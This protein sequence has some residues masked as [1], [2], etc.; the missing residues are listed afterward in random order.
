MG[1]LSPET[2]LQLAEACLRRVKG[3]SKQRALAAEIARLRGAEALAELAAAADSE[4]RQR[5]DF[6]ADCE[7]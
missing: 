6:R 1:S 3:R 2:Q 4:A 5:P 7:G